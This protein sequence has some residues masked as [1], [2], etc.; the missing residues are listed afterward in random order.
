MGAERVIINADDLGI[1]EEVN[2]AIFDLMAQRRIS[3]ATLMANGPALGHAVSGSKRFPWC[4]FGAHL[5]LTQFRPVHSGPGSALLVDTDGL[6]SR[7]IVQRSFGPNLFAAVYQE[8]CAQVELLSSAGVEL[9]H[10]DSHHHVHTNPRLLPVLKA[11]QR[12][13]RIRK[14][15]LAKNIYTLEQSP[16][17][18]LQSKK[19]VYNW[20]LR[21]LYATRT[22]QGFTDLL[23]YKTNLARGPVSHRSVELMVH[24]GA[25]YAAEE[26]AVLKSDWL[27]ASGLGPG[28]IGYN[29]F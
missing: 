27:A 17:P 11:L 26:T 6:M 21:N 16:G 18:S 14:V 3:S 15:R 19:L 10:F 28:L 25:A 23:S 20:I 5:N 1:S 4:S 24:P 8:L 12:R 13:F 7:G 29:E 9:S 22:T 2:E